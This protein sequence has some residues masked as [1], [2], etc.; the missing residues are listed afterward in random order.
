[1]IGSKIKKCSLIGCSRD[2]VS[3]QGEPDKGYCLT[4]QRMIEELQYGRLG[5]D[6]PLSACCGAPSTDEVDEDQ[7][8]IC[9]ECGEHAGFDYIPDDIDEYKRR[10]E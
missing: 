4:H 3:Y 2:Y 6:E 7:L 1:M 9:S 8:G 5:V 10:E